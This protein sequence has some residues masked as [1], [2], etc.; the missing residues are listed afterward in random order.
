MQQAHEF[1]AN[2]SPSKSNQHGHPVLLNVNLFLPTKNSEKPT[3]FIPKMLHNVMIAKQQSCFIL[4]FT[5]HTTLIQIKTLHK[6]LLTEKGTYVESIS[7]EFTQ[8]F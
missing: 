3:A 1:A 2:K 6:W 5:A 4:E 8:M 7:I